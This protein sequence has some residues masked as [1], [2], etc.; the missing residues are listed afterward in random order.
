MGGSGIQ[1]NSIDSAHTHTHTRP[2]NRATVC[3]LYNSLINIHL[4][5]CILEDDA[6]L[7]LR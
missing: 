1:F 4:I 5:I 2:Y 7:Y 3:V 6:F